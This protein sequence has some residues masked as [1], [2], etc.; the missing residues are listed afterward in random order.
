MPDKPTVD[1][2][3]DRDAMILDQLLVT[4]YPTAKTGDTDAIDRVIKIL[5]LKRKYR[6]DQRDGQEGWRL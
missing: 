3:T 1:Q 5:E 6:E 2:A 4:V